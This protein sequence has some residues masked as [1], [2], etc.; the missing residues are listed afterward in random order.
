MAEAT[1]PFSGRSYGVLTQMV[2]SAASVVPWAPSLARSTV[3]EAKRSG[4]T[5][6]VRP[7]FAITVTGPLLKATTLPAKPA[8]Q[9][10]EPSPSP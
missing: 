8:T 2:E 1:R 5:T 9:V 6:G 7:V 10:S 4:R 3:A